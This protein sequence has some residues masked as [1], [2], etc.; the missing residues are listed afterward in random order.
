MLRWICGFAAFA[1]LG[2]FAGAQ[3]T[4][5][6]DDRLDE[7]IVK[8]APE[9]RSD[10]RMLLARA[11]GTGRRVLRSALQAAG[12]IPPQ[13]G[14]PRAWPTK[15]ALKL[16]SAQMAKSESKLFTSIFTA[17][18]KSDQTLIADMLRIRAALKRP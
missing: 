7:V 18:S 3:A 4:P 10:A 13:P 11:S 5:R 12:K 16:V 8:L 2:A 17:M 15:V 6:L 14:N 9:R 1:V